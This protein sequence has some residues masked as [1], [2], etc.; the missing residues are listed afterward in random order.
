MALVGAGIRLASLAAPSGLERLLA[1]AP[2]AAALAVCQAVLL[3]L[4]G[5]GTEPLVLAAAACLTW[6]ASR[7][8]GAPDPGVPREAWAWWGEATP[9]AR[10]A[11][12]AGAGVITG[13]AAWN[14]Y[15]PDVGIDGLYYHLP[16]VVAWVQN[17]RPGSHVPIHPWFHVG[18]YPI[19]HEVLLAWAMGISRSLVPQGLI[20]VALLPVL[21]LGGWVALRNL[22]VAEPV[23][24]LAIAAMVTVPFLT[25]Q[26]DGPANEVPA[27]AWL[28]CAAGLG[29]AARDRPVLLWPMVIAA[30]LAV[31]AKTTVLPLT[32]V[33]VAFALWRSRDRLRSLAWPLMGAALVA[34]IVGVS[35][36]LRTLI[37]HGSPFWP[38]AATPW[39][40]PVPPLVDSYRSLF[41]SPRATLEGNVGQ[42]VTVM[43]G[44]W[45]TL[46]AA[47]L[48]PLWAPRREVV[49][50]SSLVAASLLLWSLAPTTGVSVF[51]ELSASVSGTRFLFPVVALAA[52]TLAL[53][54]RGHDAR[55]RV[56]AVALAAST[57]W[58]LGQILTGEF[59]AA[60]SGLWL[61]GGALAGGLLAGLAAPGALPRLPSSRRLGAG[62]TAVA[63]LV[64]AAGLAV[65]ANGYSARYA[66]HTANFDGPLVRLFQEAEIAE[67]D[68]PISMTP[69][70]FGMLTG[71]DLDRRVELVAL[72]EPCGSVA[73]RRERGWVIIREDRLYRSRL[74]YTVGDCLADVPPT[75]MVGSYRVYS[76]GRDR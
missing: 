10:I 17:G 16:E 74:G 48:S 61:V 30:G 37:E 21:A 43:A 20:G 18:S 73:A 70:I 50:G 64:T 7:R 13:W 14:L 47:I 36:Y 72:D 26:V 54:A 56:G 69:E 34:G 46:G 4:V 11:I 58:S 42:Y 33:L 25:A 23:R 1:A 2:I 66:F 39:G 76:P 63:A 67:D 19:G 71:D 22:G 68:R 9:A 5:L 65:A 35:W 45:L 12:G 51:P 59:P 60:F 8:L 32:V 41:S 75:A 31:G 62:L 15:R 53:S 6:L 27:M 3:G 57:A 52:F 49:A 44:G 38:Y 28:V 29:A 24:W 40:D 55:G